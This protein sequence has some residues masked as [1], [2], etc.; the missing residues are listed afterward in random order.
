MEAPLKNIQK[1]THQVG[2]FGIKSLNLVISR[3]KNALSSRTHAHVYFLFYK[4]TYDSAGCLET[5][6]SSSDG[7]TVGNSELEFPCLENMDNR[8][9]DIC[10]MEL[11]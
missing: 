3:E 8:T 2:Y 1:K 10:L 6:G 5:I 11:L 7:V 4:R 9:R